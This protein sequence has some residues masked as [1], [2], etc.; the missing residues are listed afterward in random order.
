MVV[1]EDVVVV[2]VL[3]VSV[4]VVGLV[5][6]VFVS[7]VSVV[8]GGDS[9][10][11]GACSRAADLT[12]HSA[13]IFGV[14]ARRAGCQTRGVNFSARRAPLGA[15]VLI[16]VT[17]L[18]PL[19]WILARPSAQPT[20]RFFAELCGAEA[21][22]LLS[23]GLVLTTL[24]TPIERAFGGLDRVAVWHRRVAVAAVLLLVPHVALV[25]STA[26]PYETTLGHG[27]G[28]VALLGILVVT[29]WAF[30]PKLRTAR[31]PGPIR[32]LA[33]TSY[34][35]WLTAHR[36]AG[37]FVAVAVVH[38]AIVDPVLHR[39][40]LLRVLLLVVGGIGVL[41][42]LYR[43]L[44]ARYVIPIYDYTVAEVRRPNESTIE[45]ALEPVGKQLSFTPG[46]FVV[47]A[48]GGESAWQRHP[49]SIA[50]APRQHQ[51]E[52]EIKAAGDYTNT[53]G[54]KLRT[55]TP[56]KLAGPFGGFD[57]RRGG[58]NQ[59]WIAA[60]IG[61]TPFLS[62]TRSLDES[63]DRTVDL[64]YSVAAESDALDLNELTAAA[65]AHPTLRLHVVVTEQQ[66][67]LTPSKV[68]NDLHDGDVWIYMCGPPPMMK[69]FEHG[70]RDLGI[71]LDKIRWEQFDIR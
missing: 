35:R 22:L 16:V 27:L 43:E 18:Y 38:A 36:F 7:V 53:L 26:D 40:T 20:G 21:V 57:Y 70:F 52:V 33:R 42:Y 68:L 69:V 47:L 30:A 14:R 54:E 28:D 6:A 23:C 49:F 34:E 1:S 31:W 5:V 19:V 55:G 37:L 15:V 63:F 41:A 71:P 11:A 65:A 56:A 45:V 61:I 59:V 25:G 29:V 48:F 24:P 13:G 3:V 64:Y 51:L 9:A 66:A 39:S 50:S 62:W 44:I 8:V 67:L 12:G 4:L 32:A 46:Q 2:S 58:K 10:N 17:A 60:G